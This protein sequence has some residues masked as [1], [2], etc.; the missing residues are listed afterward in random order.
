MM[1]ALGG[2]MHI[3]LTWTWPETIDRG[4]MVVISRGDGG[5]PGDS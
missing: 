3:S 4:E 5:F 1:T 2:S